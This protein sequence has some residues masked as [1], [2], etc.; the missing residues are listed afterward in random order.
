[1]R[2]TSPLLLSGLAVAL[3]LCALPALAQSQGD[4][5]V[6]IGAHQVNPKSDNGKL[7]RHESFITKIFCTELGFRATD[8][9]MQLHGGLGLT[10]DLPIHKMWKDSR[11]FMITEGAVEVMRTVL[12]REIFKMYT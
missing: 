12:A 2:K 8:R 1:M 9:C 7:A 6:G 5:T 3:S 11:S 10:T 4:W